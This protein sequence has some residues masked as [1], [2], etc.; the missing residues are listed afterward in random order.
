LEL[1]ETHL[2]LVYAANNLLCENM[3]IIKKSTEALLGTGKEVGL[4]VNAEKTECMFMSCRQTT[5]QNHYM[6]RAGK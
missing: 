4:E 3:N 6:K 5:G 1:N 2:F